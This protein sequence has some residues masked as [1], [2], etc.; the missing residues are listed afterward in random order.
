LLAVALMPLAACASATTTVPPIAP[1]ATGAH[2]VGQFVWYDLLTND[3]E[4]AKR[5]YGGL[6]GWSFEDGGEE[7]PVYT[8]IVHADRA[9]GGIAYT[10]KMQR[11]VNAS[12]WVSNLS[13]AD[14]DQAVEYVIGQ[15]GTIAAEAQ[16]LPDRGRV[17][18]I[19]D[20]QGA[21]VALVRSQSG[22]P[23]LDRNKVGSWLWTELWTRDSEAS[24]DFY[25]GLVG[26]EHRGL[27]DGAPG[28][29]FVFDRDGQAMAGVLSYDLE[30][31]QPNWLPYILV[32][33]PAA[34]VERVEAL[35][36]RVLIPPDPDI[37]GGSA[38]VIAD[39]SGAAL[40]IQKWP[41]EG[42]SR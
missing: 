10:A 27:D 14:V 13:V 25:A 24:I 9:I 4:G 6:F 32:D 17:A 22:D 5:F 34:I 15:G 29:Y 2:N 1:S 31:V 19:R 21:L 8:T 12:Q 38:A 39:P 26:Y 40:T 11:E 36:G 30:Q 28:A 33:D 42:Q 20:P 37:R 35:G 16:D 23:E 3:L 7:E 18:V 41:A